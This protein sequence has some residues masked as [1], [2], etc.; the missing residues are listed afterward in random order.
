M[1]ILFGYTVIN[2][3]PGFY[4]PGLPTVLFMR[5]TTA[6]HIRTGVAAADAVA[7]GVTMLLLTTV[8]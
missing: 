6:V 3:L 8:L 1:S 5:F 7:V 2:Y 4:I